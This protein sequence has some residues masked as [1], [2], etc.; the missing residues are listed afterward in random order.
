MEIPKILESHRAYL[1]ST[2]E[3]TNIM[4]LSLEETKPW[5]SKV[6]GLSLFRRY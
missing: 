3:P 4:T 1:E 2:Y 6:G 5:E